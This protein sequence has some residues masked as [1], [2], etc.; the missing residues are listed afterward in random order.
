MIPTRTRPSQ[1]GR[2]HASLTRRLVVL[3]LLACA[4]SFMPPRTLSAAD[5]LAPFV[6]ADLNPT[7]LR[8]GTPVSP[9]NYTEW[10][11]AYYFGNEG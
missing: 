5:P 3:A 9:P 6:L 1:S 7:S 11:S 8:V 4:A 2:P 10:I